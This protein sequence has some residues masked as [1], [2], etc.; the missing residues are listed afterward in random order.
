MTRGGAR[1][2]AMTRSAP[3]RRNLTTCSCARFIMAQ[4]S[5]K[6]THAERVVPTRM[7]SG[8]LSFLRCKEIEA[9]AR[10]REWT[11][12]RAWP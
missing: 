5:R 7:T 2:P 11:R 12:G 8:G 6:L 10:A 1:E 3:P 9:A 4:Q